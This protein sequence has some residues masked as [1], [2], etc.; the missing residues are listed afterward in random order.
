[1]DMN[2]VVIFHRMNVLF[3]MLLHPMVSFNR[4]YT[5]R[6][7]MNEKKDNLEF[8]LVTDSTSSKKVVN[9]ST[10]TSFLTCVKVMPKAHSELAST[11]SPTWCGEVRGVGNP[12]VQ[13]RDALL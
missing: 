8:Y 1:M 9:N 7:N 10:F 2:E 12:L 3:A 11:W 13:H 6:I 5:T 4:G